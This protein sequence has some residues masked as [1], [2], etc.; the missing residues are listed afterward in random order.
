[1]SEDLDT[2]GREAARISLCPVLMRA[3]IIFIAIILLY[4]IILVEL[5]QG[6][7]LQKNHLVVSM[8]LDRNTEIYY[9]RYEA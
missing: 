8:M 9:M 6:L 2:Q 5:D 1:M 4:I 7:V 3:T